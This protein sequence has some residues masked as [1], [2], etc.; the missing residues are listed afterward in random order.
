MIDMEFTPDPQ[1][2]SDIREQAAGWYLARRQGLDPARA[3]QFTRWL[4]TSP[5]HLAEYHAMDRL[6]QDLPLVVDQA[7]PVDE[8]IEQLRA[9]DDAVA[10]PA[11][12]GPVRTAVLS[13]YRPLALAAMIAFLAAA[14]V[15]LW[16]RMQDLLVPQTGEWLHV[17]MPGEVKTLLLRDG[18]TVILDTDSAITVR[19]DETG[20]HVMLRRGR[21]LFDVKRAGQRLFEVWA[22]PAHVV[23]LGTKFSVQLIPDGTRV[24]VL[25]GRVEVS[26]DSSDGILGAK[27]LGAGEQVDIVLFRELPDPERIDVARALGWT[28]AVPRF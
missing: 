12:A 20:R 8:L 13:R 21:A 19:Y 5:R 17:S 22:G 16:T 23:D 9:G 4:A 24:T 14:V 15:L 6:G 7:A 1:Q 27:Q 10:A 11:A 25:E 26:R 28:K 3:R 2:R 18:T